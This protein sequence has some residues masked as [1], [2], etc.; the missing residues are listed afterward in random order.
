[1]A[2]ET[3]ALSPPS[4]IQKSFLLLRWLL[5]IVCSSM[6]VVSQNLLIDIRWAHSMVLFLIL[7]NLVLHFAPRNSFTH[8]AAYPAIAVADIFLIT[9][10]LVISG[11]TA[12]DFYMMYFIIVIISALSQE[13]VQIVV[14]TALVIIL[15]GLILL[16][17]ATETGLSDSSIL[18]RLPFFFIIALFYGHLVRWLHTERLEKEESVADYQRA[19]RQEEIQGL[20]KELSLDITSMDFQSLLK[21]LT[22]RVREVFKVDICDVRLMEKG[23]WVWLSVSG[24]AEEQL[25]PEGVV[26]EQRRAR[27]IME[28]RRALVIPD[29]KDDPDRPIGE[30]LSRLGIRGYLG[31]PLFSRSGEVIG[32]LRVLS[33]QPRAFTQ[34]EVDLL[35]QLANEAAVALENAR[36]IASLEAAN[37]KLERSLREQRALQ[38][39]L[40]SLQLLD[41]DRL[42]HKVAEEAAALF[43]AEIAVVRLFDESGKIRMRAATGD[44]S[45][46]RLM[47]H[48]E[49]GKLI[50]RG[51]WMLDN[52][53]P[54]T[55]KDMATD[56]AMPYHGAVKA[57]ELRGFLGAPLFSKEQKPLGVMFVMT[58]APREFTQ[59]DVDLVEQFAKG[60]AVA[61]E[62]A[63]LFDEVRRKTQEL[64]D[65][66]ETKSD[67][68]NTMAHELRTPLTVVMGRQQLFLEGFYG[69]LNQEQ[70]QALD[71]IGRNTVELL[72]LISEILN[73]ARLEAKREP[74]HMEEIDLKEI[75]DELESSFRPLVREKELAL[76][77]RMDNPLAKLNSDKA[78]IKQVIQNLLANAI[79]YTEKGEIEL[80]IS[81]LPDG[82]A[83]SSRI[84]FAV[85]DT[86]IGI[87]EKDL[88]RIFEAFYMAE[89]VDRRKYPGSGLGLSIVKRLAE[90]LGGDIRVESEWG[91]G[92]TFRVALPLIRPSGR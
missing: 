48:G 69:A 63:R 79:K 34:E 60:A 90:L 36:L 19:K 7:S 4:P 49:E 29:L 37:I 51:R 81:C 65:A 26:T 75:V 70:R 24:V 14:S 21:K 16:W 85:R 84:S 10:A 59:R 91:K 41:L 54:L 39:L 86:G 32:I 52:R 38:G 64:E 77:F 92:S 2:A 8:P 15:Y 55:V 17:T 18:L 76:T 74:L 50:G 72:N 25:R 40:S 78:K 23:S 20:L 73:L 22:E 61:I 28:S 53:R 44:A 43:Q 66:Y 47:H 88:G 56:P 71:S 46:V 30:T 57:A 42:L 62:N 82:G 1:M 58:R 33:Y 6:I 35:Q 68:L 12:T 67:F 27:W 3:V 45:V 80:S 5:I 9:S 83:D 87:R 31:L 13:L 89:N 11:Q